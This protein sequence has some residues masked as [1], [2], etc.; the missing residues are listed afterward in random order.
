MTLPNYALAQRVAAP[1]LTPEQERMQLLEQQ[2]A[3]AMRNAAMQGGQNVALF[4]AGRAFAPVNPNMASVE[5]A[6]GQSAEPIATSTITGKGTSLAG[7]QSQEAA[8]TGLP[9]FGNLTAMGLPGYGAA[10]GVVGG[11]YL[12]GR[13]LMDSFRNAPTK[14]PTDLASRA[15]AGFSTGGLSEVARIASSLFGSGKGKDQRQ[16]DSL[17]AAAIDTGL[18]NDQYQANLG[19]GRLGDI[20]KEELNNGGKAYAIDFNNPLASELVA[21]VDPISEAFAQ[22]DD[23]KRSD[24]TGLL[25]NQILQSGVT[26]VEE[27]R[28]ALLNVLQNFRINP[29]ELRAGFEQLRNSGAITQDRYN[30]QSANLGRL[31]TGGQGR[32]A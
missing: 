14:S 5:A 2:R 20:G 11:T 9:A 29:Q 17:R 4:E 1:A 24:F 32:S 13:G 8:Q 26:S 30:V 6:F 15:Q 25:V 31:T 3:E 28:Q 10:A 12:L 19:G 16:R 21:L 7:L 18:I 22:G 27:G 23:K